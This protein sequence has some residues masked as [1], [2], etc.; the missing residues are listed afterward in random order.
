MTTAPADQ[1]RVGLVS[2]DYEGEWSGVPCCSECYE[3]HERGEL[4]VADEYVGTV[5]GLV[6][7]GV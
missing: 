5:W 4:P 6:K 1:R 7:I 3:R 2:N